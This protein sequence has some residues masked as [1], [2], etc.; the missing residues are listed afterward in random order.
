MGGMMCAMKRN[1]IEGAFSFE[2]LNKTC[3]FRPL[4]SHT[5]YAIEIKTLMLHLIAPTQFLLDCL[6]FKISNNA[7]TYLTL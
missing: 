1:N 7:I 6:F 2:F 3:G 5:L 4:G